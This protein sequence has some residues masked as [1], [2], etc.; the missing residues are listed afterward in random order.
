M[1]LKT[2]HPEVGNSVFPEHKQ[3][4][5]RSCSV[6]I[7]SSSESDENSSRL[8]AL[9]SSSVSAS[10]CLQMVGSVINPKPLEN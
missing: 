5:P 2:L 10:H 7:S 9:T 8:F 1:L 4:H 3:L 6:S